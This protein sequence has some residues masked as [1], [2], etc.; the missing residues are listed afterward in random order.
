M[1]TTSRI[2]MTVTMD[3]HPSPEQS[4]ADAT[5]EFRKLFQE[6]LSNKESSFWGDYG[7]TLEEI[8]EYRENDGEEPCWGGYEGP[9]VTHITVR[10]DD[11]L[12]ARAEVL[13]NLAGTD[14]N[15]PAAWSDA[16]EQARREWDEAR[17]SVYPGS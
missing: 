11:A 5:T 15:D 9:F 1:T 17:E 16:L 3:I 7:A 4:L 8:K 6:Y 2:T 10:D 12:H 14:P 13:A